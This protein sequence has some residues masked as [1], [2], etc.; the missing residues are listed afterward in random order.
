MQKNTIN[1]PNCNTVIN[2]NE[3]LFKQVSKEVD[4]SFQAMLK[5]ELKRAEEKYQEKEIELKKDLMKKIKAEVTG[6][7]SDEIALLKKQVNEKTSQLKDLEKFKLD[8]EKLRKEKD[9]LAQN[10]KKEYELKTAKVVADETM[11]VR[12]KI[13]TDMERKL[14]EKDI[15]IKKIQ[16]SLV[17]ANRKAEE[18]SIQ[19]K[20]E[21][22][23][24]C[25]ENSLKKEFPEDIISAVKQGT[26]GGDILH[27]VMSNGQQC[28]KIYYESKRTS[29]FQNG[30]IKK[31]K[32]D[33]KSEQATIGVIITESMP[34]GVEDLIQIEG[35]W[36][37]SFQ[38]SEIVCRIL[39]EHV[40]Q[41]YNSMIT[42]K[43]KNSKMELLY[44]YLTGEQFRIT[45]ETF[46]NTLA[47]TKIQIQKEKEAA[48]KNFKAREEHLK[49]LLGSGADICLSVKEITG[50]QINNG[51]EKLMLN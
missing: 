32:E 50:K 19:L 34:S 42:V 30:W 36:I 8:A 6:E 24:I 26:K 38:T 12:K 14:K 20:G 11:K 46:F 31:L 18:V 23:E 2:V 9:E 41:L 40:I 47:E 25:I 17:E 13:E 44:K 15:H 35:I 29:S 1:C 51:N 43:D 48:K 21:A 49:I 37:C 22:Q 4:V 45:I 5:A 33:M 3:V 10:I 27:T 39:R 16:K 7:Y 28:A